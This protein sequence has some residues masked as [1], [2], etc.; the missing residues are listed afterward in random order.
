MTACRGIDELCRDT[1]PTANLPCAA[2]EHIAYPELSGYLLYVKGSALIGE[3]SVT[4][5]D[6]EPTYFRE[7]RDYVLGNA[8][9][10]E[11]LVGVPGHAYERHDRD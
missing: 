10:E 2:L 7:S 1:N 8:I 5:D 3:G 4:C 11:L 9:S 6:E